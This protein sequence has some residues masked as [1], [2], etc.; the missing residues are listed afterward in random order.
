MLL[1]VDVMVMSSAYDAVLMFVVG[2]EGISCMYRL[3][4]E[5]DRTE[6]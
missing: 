2:G 3:K 5:G 6:P 1:F 4:R